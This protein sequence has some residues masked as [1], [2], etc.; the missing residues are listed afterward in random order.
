[1]KTVVQQVEP[2]EIV[3]GYRARIIHSQTMTLAY[4]DIEAGAR[5]PEHS[6]VHE[7]VVNMLDGSFELTVGGQKLSLLPGDVVVIPSNV[8]HS[9]AAITRSRILDVFHPIREDFLNRN[10]AYGPP[11]SDQ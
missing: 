3:P 4:V 1:M 11:G 7:Q 2:F 8:P 5:L 10:V 9:G 6:H